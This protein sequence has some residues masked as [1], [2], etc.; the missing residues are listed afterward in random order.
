MTLS[1]KIVKGVSGLF[2]RSLGYVFTTERRGPLLPEIPRDAALWRWD[3]IAGTGKGDDCT[4]PAFNFFPP[5]PSLLTLCGG[6]FVHRR[7]T[8]Q[9]SFSRSF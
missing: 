8:T 7:C 3:I 1:E 5:F 4:V 6:V 2:I 9:E